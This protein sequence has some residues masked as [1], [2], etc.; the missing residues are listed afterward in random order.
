[1]IRRGLAAFG[2][3]FPCQASLGAATSTRFENLKLSQ[4]SIVPSAVL[5]QTDLNLF[6][7]SRR[8]FETCSLRAN[9]CG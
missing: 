8:W 2:L 3:G 6:W 1:M 7:T 4:T 9:I 5:R